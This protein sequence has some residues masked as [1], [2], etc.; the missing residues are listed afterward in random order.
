MEFMLTPRNPTAPHARVPFREGTSRW[1]GKDW[2]T[3]PLRSG[4]ANNFHL[5]QLSENANHDLVLRFLRDVLL[6]KCEGEELESFL[7]TWL[8][9]GLIAE[10]L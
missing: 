6:K 10:F 5:L 3:Y 8:F 9:F 1:D 4:Y 7:Q 2:L